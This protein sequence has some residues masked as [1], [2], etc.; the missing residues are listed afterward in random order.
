MVSIIHNVFPEEY[1]NY[2]LELPEVIEAKTKLTSGQVY[3]NIQI[4]DTIRDAMQT[5]GVDLSKVS[6]VPL[7]WIKGDTPVHNDRGFSAFKNT[8]LVYINN[9]VG[10]IIIDS[11]EYPIQQNTAFIFN[12]GVLHGT[13]NTGDSPRLLL[14][15]MNEFAQPVGG[16][17]L[18]NYYSSYSDAIS[19]SNRIAYHL[20]SYI[21][22]DPVETIIENAIYSNYTSWRIARLGDDSTPPSG[23]YSNGL[24]LS[25]IGINV[26]AFLYPP[27]PCFLEGTKILCNI[28]GVDTYMNIENIQEGILVKTLTSGYKKVSII[29]KG[30]IKNAG[31]DLRTQNRLYKCSP[32]NYPTLTE[33]LYITGCHSILVDKL[34][35]EEKQKTIESLG[36]LFITEK[37]FRLNACIDDRAE[38]WNSEGIYTIWHLALENT[39]EKM[40]YGIYANGLLVES[41][42]IFFLKNKSNMILS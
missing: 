41:C 14:G 16:V 19:D 32:N 36:Q 37:K 17:P 1:L 20:T 18:I 12:E 31:D 3:F 28:E 25:S 26:A 29:G 9:S 23:V 42:S 7:R 13:L 34:T 40:N 30:E 11:T 33:D 24:D 39:N 38:P 35:N 15:P 5:L 8:Y 27:A 2:I 21:L 10:D 22:G 6:T 4:T